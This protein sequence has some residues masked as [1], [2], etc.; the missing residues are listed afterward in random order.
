MTLYQVVKALALPPASLCLL[1]VAGLILSLRWWRAGL[2]VLVVAT[3]VFYLLSAQFVANRLANGISTVPPLSDTA[4]VSPAQAIVILSAGAFVGGPEFGG[5]TL[6]HATLDR[7][8]YG[9]H[10]YH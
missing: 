3:L 5:V 2:T 10:L 8:R 9:A 7:L 6:D 1:L 4:D